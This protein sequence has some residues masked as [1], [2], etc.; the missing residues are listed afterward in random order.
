M[1]RLGDYILLLND[2]MPLDMCEKLIK[3][4]DETKE[5]VDRNTECF[6]FTEINIFNHS[7]F[8]EFKEPMTNL[9]Q[10]VHKFYAD[11]TGS[12]FFPET[13]AYEAP[14]IQRYEPKEGIFDWHLD[15]CNV[16]S[17]RRLLVMF[18]YLNDVEEGGETIF[19]IGTEI[20]VKPKA[21]SVC[22][23]PPNFLFPHKG[24]TPISNPKYVVSSYVHLP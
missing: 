16:E 20:K 1:K 13:K 11:K 17:S 4:Y 19:D 21:G 5:R 18:W 9:M 6:K 22:C 8:D 12:K 3:T 2:V 10:S 24:A 7:N 23:F 14:R 15:S